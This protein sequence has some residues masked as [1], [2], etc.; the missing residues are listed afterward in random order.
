MLR[1]IAPLWLFPFIACGTEGS[2]SETTPTVPMGQGRLAL[3]IAAAF[4]DLQSAGNGK[5]ARVL[6]G[7]SEIIVDIDEV[8]AHSS[9]A[10]WVVLL[11][12]PRRVDILRLAD[13][14][15]ELGFADLPPGHISQ[16]RLHVAEDSSPF[17]TDAEGATHPLKVPSG[18]QSGIKLKGLWD[19]HACQVTRVQARIDRR[20]SIHVISTGHGDQ[21]ILRPVIFAGGTSLEAVGCGETPPGE[22]GETPPGVETGG[23]PSGPLDPG[24]EGTPGEG[25]APG[26]DPEGGTPGGETP[27]GEGGEIPPVGGDPTVPESPTGGGGGEPDE[28]LCE[29]GQTCASGYHCGQTGVCIPSF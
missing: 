25:D 7:L 17:V 27:P 2:V 1:R 4:D 14:A 29:S 19:L 15:V 24:G 16:I 21:H 26:T 20:N 5:P 18:M 10:G 9:E 23:D 11:R 8:T 3:E 13:S 28:G 12:E 22:G 6:A